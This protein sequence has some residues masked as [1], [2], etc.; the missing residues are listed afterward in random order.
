MPSLN[1][2]QLVGRVAASPE[3]M[4]PSPAGERFTFLVE[5]DRDMTS[6]GEACPVK[7]FHRIVIGRE[8]VAAC[9]SDLGVGQVV[10]VEGA[11]VN[12]G[13][14]KDGERRFITEIHAEHIEVQV[15]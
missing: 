7:D 14:K 3:A 9:G 6:D 10:R 8:I 12:R 13:Y 2:V 15:E 11:L 4:K 5:T 1:H